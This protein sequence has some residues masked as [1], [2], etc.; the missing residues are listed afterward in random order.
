MDISYKF[1][2][3]LYYFAFPKP[4]H[5]QCCMDCD[6]KITNFGKRLK[7]IRFISEKEP[8][9]TAGSLKRFVKKKF[10]NIVLINGDLFF[11]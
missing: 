9:G 11:R 5:T 7:N 4:C 8:L 1:L 2:K 10:K 3:S 6:S